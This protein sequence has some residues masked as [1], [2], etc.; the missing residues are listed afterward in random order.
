MKSKLIILCIL[1]TL[2][3]S[4]CDQLSKE[5][6][7]ERLQKVYPNCQVHEIPQ[8]HHD[9]S[10]TNLYIVKTSENKVLYIRF[11]AGGMQDPVVVFEDQNTK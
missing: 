6:G 3:F 8:N 1:S 7:I 4:G 2:L 9:Q 11:W 10:R 5:Q